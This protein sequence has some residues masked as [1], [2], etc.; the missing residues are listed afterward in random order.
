MRRL[1]FCLI[2]LYVGVCTFTSCDEKEK[3]DLIEKRDDNK[4]G[5]KD[6]TH[7]DQGDTT[8]VQ[9]DTVVVNALTISQ[10]QAI[11]SGTLNSVVQ[12]IDFN[13]LAQALSGIMAEMGDY[14][15]EFDTL[16]KY[17]SIQDPL[18]G[19]KINAVKQIF[20]S[21][22]IAFDF[23]RL[24][25]EADLKLVLDTIS[26]PDGAGGVMDTIILKPI[27]SNQKHEN[28]DQIKLNVEIPGNKATIILKGSSDTQ[29]RIAVDNKKGETVNIT[30]PKSLELSVILNEIP[31]LSAN[32]DLDTDFIVTAQRDESHKLKSLIFNGHDLSLN[33]GVT[34]GKYNITANAAYSDNDNK[35]LILEA[36]AKVFAGNYWNDMLSIKAKVDATIPQDM[37]W[38]DFG[39]DG[40]LYSWLTTDMDRMARGVDVEAV[41]GSDD[42]KLQA[43]VDL[44]NNEILT[45]L[46]MFALSKPT[47]EDG[48]NA[49]NKIVTNLNNRIKGELYFKDYD[50]PQA[51]IKFIY[52]PESAGE[53]QQLDLSN[54][55][56]KILLNNLKNS[57]LRIMI[58]TYDDNK[59]PVTVSFQE[60]FG[61]IDIKAMGKALLSKVT[62]AFGPLLVKK[63]EEVVPGRIFYNEDIDHGG[64]TDD[65]VK[66]K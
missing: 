21:N 6:T 45:A 47:G 29:S 50:D 22:N 66:E 38:M 11:L 12:I 7:T 42:I 36:K 28:V 1:L 15:I 4:G 34:L 64:R 31:V 43:S 3:N 25:F 65:I 23:N 49:A 10:Q 8:N 48:L 53:Y 14:S 63:V 40:R 18:L 33:A 58:D 60:Y 19:A 5:Q 54:I 52:D 41:L 44:T 57:G 51:K 20:K 59:K 16:I 30:L 61:A 35:G 46:I 17:I 62:S 27:V 55:D 37:N 24:N 9:G 56:K 26:V 13:D 2:A 39:T 32:Y